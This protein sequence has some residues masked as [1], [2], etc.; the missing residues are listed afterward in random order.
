MPR[1]ASI[2]VLIELLAELA[3]EPEPDLRPWE[4]VADE[5][6][7]SEPPSDRVSES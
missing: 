1:P 5:D 3:A 2:D 6:D 4:P 7:P